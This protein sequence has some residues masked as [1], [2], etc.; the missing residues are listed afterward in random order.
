M[1]KEV[2]FRAASLNER[3]EFYEKEFNVNK[4][5]NWFKSNE[6]RIPQLCAIDAGT[7]SGIIINKKLK[8]QLLYFQ[9]KD[10]IKKIKKYIPEDVYYCRNFYNAPERILKT[11]KVNDWKEQELVFDIDS[12][13]IVCD[14]G[15]NKI[16]DLSIKEALKWTNKMVIELK[17]EFKKVK[18]VY[19]GRGFHVHVLDKEAFLLS[20]KQ[21]GELNNK[22]SAYP[23]DPWVSRGYIDLIRMPYSLNALVSR[24]VIPVDG[25]FKKEETYP[26][27]LRCQEP[28]VK[29]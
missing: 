11:F 20:L 19:S 12:D 28:S 7:E 8:N 22:F 14:C 4:V 27:F 10:L 9:F 13:N 23:I 6:M 1:N 24:K 21:R 25:K 15:K 17:R 29:D 18:V 26:R 16:C 2:E 3:K 5:K